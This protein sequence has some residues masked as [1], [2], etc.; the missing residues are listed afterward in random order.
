MKTC[1][2][3]GHRKIKITDEL[4]CSIRRMVEMLICEENVLTFVFG[5]KSMFND[6][7]Y[8][9]VTEVKKEYPII[10]RVCMTCKS[11]ACIME[12]ERENTEKIFSSVLKKEIHL[13]GFEE[14][15]NF[16]NKYSAGKTSYIQRNR[17]M[18]DK[19]DFCI[20]YFD[21]NY[22]PE[23]NTVLSQSGTALA[24]A[25]AKQKKKHIINLF[26]K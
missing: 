26:E 25:Y 5:S 3:I 19:S 1:C 2:F 12:S 4:R 20:F 6:L 24:Y 21:E 9:I 11:E 10:K 13:Q 7:C 14:E 16:K 15:W 17:A 18:I 23:S 8:Q 22:S